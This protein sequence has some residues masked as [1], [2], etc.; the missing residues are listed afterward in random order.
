[1]GKNILITGATGNLGLAVVKQLQSE[2]H[3]ILATTRPGKYQ[4][5]DGIDFYECDLSNEHSVNECFAKMKNNYQQLDAT[6]MLAGG[7]GM[8]NIRE[9]GKDSLDR[10]FAIN[11]YTAYFTAQQSILWMNET[12]GG[13]LIFTGAKPALEGGSASVLPYALSK[14]AVLQLA[15]AIN[16]DDQNKDI[17]ASVIVPSIIDTPPNREAMPN[18]N[19]E[20]WV[21]P[22]DIAAQ[23]GYLIA[24]LSNPLRETVLKIYNRA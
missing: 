3:Q 15:K 9:S 6:V 2:G 1:M 10:M 16:E 5:I 13:K 22:E 19:F 7:F 18:A 20:D 21:T 12:G 14:N 23:I 4:S 11:F 8:G 17:S 24:D